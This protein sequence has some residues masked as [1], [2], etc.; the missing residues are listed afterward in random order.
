MG[1]VLHTLPA[2]TDAMHAIPNLE[3]DWVVEPAFANIPA[4]HPAVKKIIPI[5]FR[6]WRKNIFSKETFSEIKTFYKTLREKKYDLIIDAQGLLKSAA[7]AKLAHGKAAGYD[8][9]SARESLS[10]IFYDKKIFIEK[11]EHA[12]TRLRLLFSKAF[13]YDFS[14]DPDFHIDANALPGVN[15][16]L[17]KKYCVFLHGTT[18]P[19]KHYSEN[20]WKILLEKA[21]AENIT[22]YLAW[23]NDIEK[24]RAERLS[25]NI[26]HAIVLPK[27]SIAQIARV[28]KNATVVV[29]V[30]TGLGHVSAALNTPTI[31]L[32]GPTDPKKVGA[33]GK[34]AVHLQ[35]INSSGNDVDIDPELI[36]NTVRGFYE[37]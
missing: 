9:N 36:W 34:N 23:G 30:D 16:S 19:T 26:T 29:T 10:S 5:N 20:H 21:N 14:G 12:I 2:L 33:L 6:H 3:I 17:A 24:N 11:N 37:K 7:V 15:F 25:K 22:V 4:W 13:S 32:Y 8:K 31:S 35:S 27:L 18:W 1:D 28:L